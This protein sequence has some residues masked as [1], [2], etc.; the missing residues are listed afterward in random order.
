MARGSSCAE[1]EVFTRDF[2][3]SLWDR[4]H[5]RHDDGDETDGSESRTPAPLDM[6]EQIC[7]A[8]GDTY[9]RVPKRVIS[10]FGLESSGTKF[11]TKTLMDA[12]DVT[13]GENDEFDT[14]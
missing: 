4:I 9:N 7:A 8:A 12:T 11:V 3:A 13:H 2:V 1:G 14:I 10:V 5:G 6:P